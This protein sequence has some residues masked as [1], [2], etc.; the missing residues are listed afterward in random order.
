M[1]IGRLAIRD[2]HLVR[3]EETVVDA[4]RRMRDERV[5]TLVVLDEDRRPRGIVTDRD[6]VRRVL[7]DDR[8]EPRTTRVEDVMTHAA[9][10]AGEDTPIETALAMMRAR[11]HRRLLVVDGTGR[12]AG[13]LSLDD[14]L[15]LLADEV[16]RMG[17]LVAEQTRPARGRVRANESSGLP[18]QPGPSDAGTSV[19]TWCQGP[20]VALPFTASAR[21]AARSMRDENVGVVV[22]L[23]GEERPIGVVSDRALAMTVLAD[24]LDPDRA[25]VEELAETADTIPESSPLDEAVA[26]MRAGWHR[27][28]VVVDGDG[29]AVGILSIDDLLPKIGWE[30]HALAELVDRQRLDHPVEELLS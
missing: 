11:H 10:T 29:R 13:I 5:G 26:R 19:G 22:V 24:A 12:L 23:D 27:R 7:C 20:A 25:A 4:A 28:L 21:D 18:A 3:P 2:V 9:Q 15:G 6:L 17:D 14:L 1:T 8:K 16:Y 30:L